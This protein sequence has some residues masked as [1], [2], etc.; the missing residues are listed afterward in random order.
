MNAWLRLLIDRRVKHA[1]KE[2]ARRRKWSTSRLFEYV[3]R[4]YLKSDYVDPQAE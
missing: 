3:W 4:I 2:E 1:F